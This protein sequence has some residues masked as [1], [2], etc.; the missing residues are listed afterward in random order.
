M[1]NFRTNSYWKGVASAQ[2]K[3]SSQ[4]KPL[5]ADSTYVCAT[6]STVLGQEQCSAKNRHNLLVLLFRAI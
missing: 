4:L 2:Y 1:H 3:Y 6:G 5:R